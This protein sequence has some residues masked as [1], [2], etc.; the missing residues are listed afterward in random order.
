M[1]DFRY[2]LR[3]LARSPVFTIV[4]VLSLSIGIGA[5][6]AVFSLLN[7]VRLRAL[8]VPAPHELRLVNWKGHTPQLASYTGVGHSR[9]GGFVLGSSFPYPAYSAFRD[10]APG[11]SSLFAF[12]PLNRRTVFGPAGAETAHGLMVSGN[13]FAGYGSPVLL[14]RALAPGDD[15]PGAAP[16]AVITYRLWERQFSCDASAIGRTL[17]VAQNAFTI[18]GVLP[19]THVGPMPGAPSSFYVTFAAQPLLESNRQLASADRWWVQIMGRIAPGMDEQQTAAALSV[20]FTRVLSQSKTKMGEPGIVLE[21]GAQGAALVL[22]NRMATPL[23]ALLAVVGLML[24]I[25]CANVGGLM[26]ARAAATEH[27]YAVRAAIGASRFRLLR[28]SFVESLLLAAMS[29]I[30]GILIADG[31]IAALLRGWLP[32]ADFQVDAGLDRNVFLFALLSSLATA[33]LFGTIPALRASRVDPLNGLK[34]LSRTASPRLRLG[35][36]LVSLQVALSVL[37]VVG[38]SLTIRTFVNLVRIDPG[39]APENVL[40]FRVSPGQAG[41][42][43]AQLTPFYDELRRRLASVPGV[44]SVAFSSQPL[45]ANSSEKNGVEFP[46]RPSAGRDSPDVFTLIVSDGYLAT[47]GIPLRLGRDLTEAD[48]ASAAPIALVNETFAR[49]HFANENPLGRSFLLQDGRNRT[50]TIVGVVGDARYDSVRNPVPP[51]AYFAHRQNER[52]ALYVSL[53]TSLEPTSL[54][55]AVRSAVA[56]LSKEVPLSE[57]QTQEDYLSRSVSTERI[58]ATLCGGVSAVALL[59]ACIGLY[60]LMAYGVSRRTAEIGIRMALGA[61]ERGIAWSVVRGALALSCIGLV[62]GIPLAL[63]AARLVKSQLYGVSAA[64]PVSVSAAVALLIGAALLA[65]WL[66]ARRAARINP[67]DALR[68]E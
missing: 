50:F 17:T 30:G 24:A 23:L 60:G 2:A 56:G 45:I 10:E 33:L 39:F 31:A 63:G 4:A 47:L 1:S 32:A 44:R 67:I 20:L 13:F 15:K 58:F 46:G 42:N 54:V 12:F 68:A 66:P 41:F 59:L 9:A 65:A 7:A 51:L 22:R 38:A 57:I 34:S 37:L 18:V 25:A 26:L 5:A 61:S 53:R 40:V 62:I 36:A 21:N 28:Q 11:F 16:V 64:D 6:T 43:G 27:D 49:T 55:P 19:Q 52:G 3:S 29:G 48:V 14:G 35:S 8:P